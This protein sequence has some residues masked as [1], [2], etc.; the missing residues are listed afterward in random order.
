MTELSLPQLLVNT[1]FNK[2]DLASQ[3]L[4]NST[5]DSTLVIVRIYLFS[6]TR[7]TANNLSTIILLGAMQLMN[8]VNV[9]LVEETN[10]KR[11]LPDQAQLG[12][13]PNYAT[14][15]TIP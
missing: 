7:P 4:S 6:H 9:M 10:V 5:P 3:Q 1:T 14:S 11:L 2:S 12:D 13:H 15:R 8:P